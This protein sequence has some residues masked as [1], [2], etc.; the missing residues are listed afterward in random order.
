MND[1]F[2]LSKCHEMTFTYED[3]NPEDVPE[4][5]DYILILE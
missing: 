3:I 5:I 2:L 4:T 1:L